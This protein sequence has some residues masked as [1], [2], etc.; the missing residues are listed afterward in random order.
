RNWREPI[1]IH[2]VNQVPSETSK[3][4]T[5]AA[6]TVAAIANGGRHR[7]RDRRGPSSNSLGECSN[8]DQPGPAN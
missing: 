1:N 7:Q 3:L 8:A 4:S 6:T 2:A 5:D